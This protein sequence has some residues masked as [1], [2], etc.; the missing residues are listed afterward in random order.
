M[1]LSLF[2]VILHAEMMRSLF[3]AFLF[4]I[5]MVVPAQSTTDDSW[6]EGVVS[7]ID[8]LLQADMFTKS[9]VGIMVYD[10]TADSYL[11][12]HNERQSLRPAST[13]KLIT[14]ITALE[15]LGEDHLFETSLYYTGYIYNGILD[16]DICCVGGFDPRFN[17]D[18][19]RAFAES[20]LR[21]GVD[22]IRGNIVGDVS[23]KDADRLGEGWCWD[24][25]N[26]VLS[27]LLVS[28]DDDFLFRLANE[29]RLEGIIIEGSALEGR[30]P[31]GAYRLCTRS[32]TFGQVLMRMMKQS[33]N[34]CAEAMFYNLA[35]RYGGSP[36]KAE[37]ARDAVNDLI[38]RLGLNPSDYY[39]ADGCGLS[40]YN[41]VTAELE[42]RLLRYAYEHPDI[43]NALYTALPVAGKDGT[44]HRR[45]RQGRAAGN[46][47]AKTGTLTR[48]SSLAGYCKSAEGH[49]LCFSILN[50]GLA[51]ESL[52]R[53]FQDKVCEILCK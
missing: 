43:Y 34:L 52:G 29:L 12:S 49:I 42:V 27:P 21:L 25:E 4:A 36:A 18:D 22:T 44:L 7:S 17:G 23:M 1:I 50:Q 19:L 3:L 6:A 9:Q 31:S 26:P 33:D 53:A 41:Y 13:M 11:Y 5:P 10:L 8:Q 45:M 37:Y 32:H 35:R 20:I 15:R 48:I 38:R 46:V 51:D 28:G 16:G 2:S 47:R 24:D 39:I 30:L 14:A 40:L